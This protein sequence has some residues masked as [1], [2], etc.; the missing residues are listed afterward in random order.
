MSMTLMLALGSCRDRADT[1]PGGEP[2][3]R[4]LDQAAV[5]DE[6]GTSRLAARRA[7][8]SAFVTRHE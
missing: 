8:G 6:A 1:F 4:A 3:L 5:G 2:G 7:P